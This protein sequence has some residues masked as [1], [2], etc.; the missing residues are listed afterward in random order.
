MS[1]FSAEDLITLRGMLIAWRR[2]L[3]GLLEQGTN[4]EPNTGA[5]VA[6]AR[7]LEILSMLQGA[8]ERADE[9]LSAVYK[10]V[11]P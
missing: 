4:L 11:A 6:G 2:D 5:I 9:R 10:Q 3:I 7:V 8:I 1:L